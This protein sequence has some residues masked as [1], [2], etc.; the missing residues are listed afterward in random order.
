MPPQKRNPASGTR[1]A[2]GNDPLGKSIT[3]EN[4]PS[5]FPAQPARPWP[6]RT[7]SPPA[8]GRRQDCGPGSPDLQWFD[9]AL[10]GNDPAGRLIL[11]Q[12]FTT[13]ADV[14]FCGCSSGFSVAE[15]VT[16]ELALRIGIEAIRRG[17]RLAIGG[18]Q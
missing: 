1:G 17:A 14:T 7:K 6:T 4:T 3:R 10:E 15:H 18:E 13:H 16:F 5:S 12:H 9:E 8:D 2:R 11:I